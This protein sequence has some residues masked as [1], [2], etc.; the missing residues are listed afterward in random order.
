MSANGKVVPPNR[1]DVISRGDRATD[2]FAAWMVEVS[3]PK[4]L[5]GSGTPES[6]MEGNK[7]WLYVDVDASAGDV[8]YAKTTDGGNTGWVK[9]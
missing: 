7:G 8:L 6:V 2:I 5:F 1:T 9:A 4:V 3:K